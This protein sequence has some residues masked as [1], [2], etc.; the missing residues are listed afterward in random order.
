MVEAR[1]PSAV[2]LRCQQVRWSGVVVR[3]VIRLL[4][5][6]EPRCSRVAVARIVQTLETESKA[7]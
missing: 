3:V 6:R 5:A 4:G 1:N 7:E 2:E